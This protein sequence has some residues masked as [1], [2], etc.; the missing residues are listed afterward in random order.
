M[1]FSDYFHIC[2]VSHVISFIGLLYISVCMVLYVVT[3]ITIRYS[4]FSLT[5]SQIVWGNQHSSNRGDSKLFMGI[6]L[7]CCAPILGK[8]EQRAQGNTL[9]FMLDPFLVLSHQ[10]QGGLPPIERWH[11]YLAMPI[12]AR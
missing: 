5:P 3:N 11:D 1:T 8:V 7:W 2:L 12:K 9:D 6:C 4:R 10:V